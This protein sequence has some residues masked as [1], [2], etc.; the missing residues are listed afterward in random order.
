MALSASLG[1]PLPL[2]RGIRARHPAPAKPRH[3]LWAGNL[4][5]ASLRIATESLRPLG[6]GKRAGHPVGE[7]APA[8][9]ALLPLPLRGRGWCVAEPTLGGRKEA[10]AAH[11]PWGKAGC[12]EALEALPGLGPGIP[13]VAWGRPFLEGSAL[14]ACLAPCSGRSATRPACRAA[15]I[16]P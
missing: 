15:T 6:L 10:T 11:R 8:P 13:G 3:Q 2:L 4:P 12:W 16:P 1:C 9:V 5:E 14:E 7:E